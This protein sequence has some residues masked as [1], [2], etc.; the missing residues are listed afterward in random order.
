MPRL[1]VRSA[2]K[3]ALARPPAIYYPS[4]PLTQQIRQKE[5]RKLAAAESGASEE[6]AKPAKS[7][8]KGLPAGLRGPPK[9]NR[10]SKSLERA[11][12][13]IANDEPHFRVGGKQIYLPISKVVLVR[14]NAKHTPY[15]AKFVVPRY[16][17][18]LD[19][20][21]YL[22]HVYGLRA[23]NVTTQLLWARWTRETPRSSRYRASQIKK[24]TIDMIDPFVWPEE[25]TEEVRQSLFGFGTTSEMRKFF[26]DVSGR[27]GSDRNKEPTAFNGLVGPFP[28]PPQPFIPKYFKKFAEREKTRALFATRQA[29]K[30]EM[31]RKFL[32]L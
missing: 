5:A 3:K 22:Y 32:K 30:E 7:K 27:L 14:P 23:L 24:M 11:K 29:E 17:N 2:K 31:V 16:F 1:V 4:V 10:A 26:D 13:A 12:E 19:L 28:D 6:P 8:K 15:Q 21:D 25:P 20:R 9:P 18:K